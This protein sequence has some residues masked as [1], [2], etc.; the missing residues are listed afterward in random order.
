MPISD[1]NERTE[2]SK[3]P[4]ADALSLA[5]NALSATKVMGPP[6]PAL[7]ELQTEGGPPHKFP[8]RILNAGFVFA[9]VLAAVCLVASTVYLY[10]FLSV[11][12]Q[13][14]DGLL[15]R[16]GTPGMSDVLIQLGINAALVSARLALL[17]CGVFVAMAFG[18]LG[19]GLFLMGI[20]GEI[21]ASGTV[22]SFGFKVAR[23][24]PGVFVMTATIALIGVCVTHRTPFD[25][26]MEQSPQTPVMGE[27]TAASILKKYA[28]DPPPLTVSTETHSGTGIHGNLAGNP[29][30]PVGP[31]SVTVETRSAIMQTPVSDR[32]AAASVAAPPRQEPLRQEPPRA[33]QAL[34][35]PQAPR[36]AR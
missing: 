22:E 13:K 25:Y 12:T 27:K 5:Q 18:F 29:G 16:A 35:A 14:I 4:M 28:Q 17:S 10:T 1:N 23:M 19:F 20:R 9:L 8:A 24:S 36:V 32:D 34:P 30:T 3:R 11:T 7:S 31:P 21:E 15:G 26:R 6:T 2:Q 33:A